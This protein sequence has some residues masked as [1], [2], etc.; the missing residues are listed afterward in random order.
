MITLQQLGNKICIIGCSNS[1]KSTLAEALSK[2]I[3]IPAYHLDQLAHAP[4]SKWERLSDDSL[5]ASHKQIMTQENWIIDGNYSVCMRERLET[6][7]A[8]IWLDMNV[9]SS[10]LRYLVRS[11]KNDPS[12]P[13]RLTG[14]QQ[15]FN[16]AL[17][18]HILFTYPQNRIKYQRLLESWPDLLLLR[19]GSMRLLQRYYKFWEL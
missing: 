1:G 10:V 18:K 5:L 3:K 2:K 14:A 13:G 8:V 4:H 19:I 6:A 12:R 7:T 15:E 17:I 16:F 9:Y 11:L